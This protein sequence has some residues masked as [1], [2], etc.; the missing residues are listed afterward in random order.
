M[1]R[2]ATITYS[3]S[4]NWGAVLQA[5]AL[6]EYLVE[7]G[8]DAKIIDYR[9]FDERVLNTVKS[10]PDGI[11]DVLLWG[12]GKRRVERFR[13][14]R[15]QYFRLTHKC[16]NAE[17]LR[18]LNPD[19]D[20]FI[21]G[22]DQVWNIGRGVNPNF[23]LH[24]ADAD[25]WKMSYAGSFGVSSIPPEHEA[26]TAAGLRN[27]NRISVREKSGAALVKKYL[28]EE[29][30]VVLDPV[31]LL[32]EEKWASVAAAP[33]DKRPYVFVYPTQ[34]TPLLKQAVRE[35][36]RKHHLRVISPFWIGMGTVRKDI[37]PAEF[38]GLVQ[39][40]SYVVASSF[41]ALA[42]SLIFRKDFLIVPH[43]STGSRV[44]DL[45]EQTG[46]ADR[47]ITSEE[48]LRGADRPVDY[49]EPGEKLQALIAASKDYLRSGIGEADAK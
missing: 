38:V 29:P 18:T 16:L 6:N 34:V 24:F 17:E 45:L 1:K 15:K 27:L 46:L 10:I 33:Q 13:Q 44:R 5:W 35:I 49:R 23:Y 26:D 19:F 14:F 21:T 37:G 8:W 22:S 41:H 48:A 47:I 43:S 32:P 4:Q 12:Q 31:F 25:K 3:W 42:F 7:Q 30:P 28:G 36:S 39:N 20:I 40:A 2:I 11:A 9:A